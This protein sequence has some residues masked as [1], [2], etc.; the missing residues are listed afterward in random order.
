MTRIS[1]WRLQSSSVST[2]RSLPPSSLL[3]PPRQTHAEL[4]QAAKLAEFSLLCEAVEM[5][6]RTNSLL[7]YTVQTALHLLGSQPKCILLRSLLLLTS[8]GSNLRHRRH[9]D[10][11]HTDVHIT[12]YIYSDILLLW[13]TIIHSVGRRLVY[14]HSDVCTCPVVSLRKAGSPALE[15]SAEGLDS[16]QTRLL[17]FSAERAAGLP[18]VSF[19]QLHTNQQGKDDPRCLLL[20]PPLC[21]L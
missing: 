18:W 3:V 21:V 19:K 5:P 8:R 6:G 13:G 7:T 4:T 9:E 11:I 20:R 14:R 1:V 12:T 17:F 10:D 2:S 16:E 15:S